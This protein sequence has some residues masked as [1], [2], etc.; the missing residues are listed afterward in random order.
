MRHNKASVVAPTVA[1]YV[2]RNKPCNSAGT[3]GSTVARNGVL[4]V[5]CTAS[6]W[7]HDLCASARLNRGT[8]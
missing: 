7:S 8:C 5:G 6:P 4:G 2:S 3:I 1:R